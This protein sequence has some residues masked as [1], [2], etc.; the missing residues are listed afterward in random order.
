MLRVVRPV[1]RWSWCA[2]PRIG[3]PRCR[4]SARRPWRNKEFCLH[5]FARWLYRSHREFVPGIK[6]CFFFPNEMITIFATDHVV[7]LLNKMKIANFGKKNR[8]QLCDRFRRIS[9]RFSDYG[10]VAE[11]DWNIRKFFL[12]FWNKWLTQPYELHRR[13]FLR[14]SFTLVAISFHYWNV[15]HVTMARLNERMYKESVAQRI[16]S[17]WRPVFKL[18]QQ[19]GS[20]YL[21]RSYSLSQSKLHR[22]V[23]GTD[24]VA[25]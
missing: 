1:V 18:K 6:N 9:F 12:V 14:N 15:P 25:K 13:D 7:D 10:L 16:W 2:V 4:A 24:A 3:S 17:K 11:C 22:A 21:A 23:G 19:Q 5:R 8:F 20:I